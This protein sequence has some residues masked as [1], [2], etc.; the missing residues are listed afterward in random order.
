MW[1]VVGEH[2]KARKAQIEKIRILK[3]EESGDIPMQHLLKHSVHF[4]TDATLEM[5]LVVLDKA[6]G[7]KGG[8]GGKGAG[9]KADKAEPL[10]PTR[11]TSDKQQSK[12]FDQARAN[13][14]V[15]KAEKGLK[16]G[17]AKFGR[18]RGEYKW[19]LFNDCMMIVRARLLPSPSP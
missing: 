5:Q 13:L 7:G 12:L 10:V 17:K 4:V 18:W 15:A 8:K 6:K 1:A 9:G 16:S 14:R 11:I 19:Y 3:H 2:L